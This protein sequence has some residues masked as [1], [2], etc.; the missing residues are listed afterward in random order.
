MVKKGQ[1]NP[2]TPSDL[3]QQAEELHA[4]RSPQNQKLT[5]IEKDRLLH[6]LEVHQ[7]ELEIQNEELRR[8]QQELQES[9]NRYTDLFD[10]APVGYF[11]LDHHQLIIAA[12]LMGAGMLGLERGKLLGTRFSRFIDQDSQ[13]IFFHQIQRQSTAPEESCEIQMRRHSG[14]LFFVQLKSLKVSSEGEARYRVTMTDITKRKQ[15]EEA[16]RGLNESLTRSTAELEAA[17]KELKDLDFAIAQDL[18]AGLRQIGGFSRILLDEYSTKLDTEGA[19]YLQRIHAISQKM[20]VYMDDLLQLSQVSAVSLKFESVSLSSIVGN[21]TTKLQRSQPQRRLELI[22][23][24]NVI[25]TGDYR[26]L[27]LALEK[28]LDNAFKFTA[29]RSPARIEFGLTQDEGRDVYFIKDNG[30]GFD[31]KYQDKL[32]IPF[33]HLHSPKDY[34]GEAVGLALAQRIFH[35]HGGS[36][37]AESEPGKGATFFFTLSRTADS[38]RI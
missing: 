6:E 3:R 25:V 16:A 11:V 7:I 31:M 35:H 34:P 37:W 20:N 22:V 2:E 9:R 5:R 30:I 27:Y 24:P 36:I 18:K 33:Q 15:A 26:L 13:S 38:S 12:N 4:G 19:D 32:F 10:F 21:I 14:E 29:S 28:L 8:T 1:T 17:N 23:K